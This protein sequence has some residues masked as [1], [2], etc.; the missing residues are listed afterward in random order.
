MCLRQNCY[1]RSDTGKTAALV[2]CRP[3]ARGAGRRAQHVGGQRMGQRGW[4]H[5][6]YVAEHARRGLCGGISGVWRGFV[7]R[8]PHHAY[9]ARAPSRRHFT[10]EHGDTAGSANMSEAQRA[11]APVTIFAHRARCPLPRSE[12][13]IA[14]HA[15]R[16][17]AC[18]RAARPVLARPPRRAPLGTGARGARAQRARHTART[19]G[20]WEHEPRPV[21]AAALALT[22]G[23][24]EG[25]EA[26]GARR[27]APALSPPTAH[28]AGYAGG[29]P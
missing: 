17:R 7:R 28:P 14:R 8:Q 21:S 6:H 13:L 11:H 26:C 3:A 24:T 19:A 25:A 27:T 20:R 1:C 10:R 4:G 2:S 23:D 12:P 29:A 18:T 9:P 22:G 5:S 16:G 15:Q